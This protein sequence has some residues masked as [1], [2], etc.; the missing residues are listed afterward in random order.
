MD[1]SQWKALKFYTVSKNGLELG[2]EEK[3]IIQQLYNLIFYA[4]SME[5]IYFCGYRAIFILECF[6]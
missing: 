4:I 5:K 3:R 1:L 2:R 6:G